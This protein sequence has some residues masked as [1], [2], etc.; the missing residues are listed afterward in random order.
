M[1]ARR[2]IWF[3]AIVT[4]GLGTSGCV[5]SFST[6]LPADTP[7]WLREMVGSIA[8]E[9]VTN[10]PTEIWAQT[11]QGKTTYWRSSRCCD[12]YSELYSASGALLCAPDGG[13]TG[14]GDGRCP[15]FADTATDRRLIWKD[16]RSY[17]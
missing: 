15:D 3:A 17:P 5:S 2:A 12:V 7:D 14:T 13:I 16:R 4:V 11:Y 6:E 9:P 10:P 8:R 1:R